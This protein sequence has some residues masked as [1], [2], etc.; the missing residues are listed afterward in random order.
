[1]QYTNHSRPQPI[2]P[3][4]HGQPNTLSYSSQLEFEARLGRTVVEWV[5]EKFDFMPIG[6]VFFFLTGRNEKFDNSVSGWNEPIVEATLS[7]VRFS[8][9]FHGDSARRAMGS[10][11]VNGVT[12]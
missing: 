10:Y 3:N 12:R 2:K 9:R 5:A 1:M 11:N 7:G 8:P 4:N 6:L